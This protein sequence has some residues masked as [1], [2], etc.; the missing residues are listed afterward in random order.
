[1]DFF[2]VDVD[3]IKCSVPYAEIQDCENIIN[4][5]ANIILES[6]GIVNPLFVKKLGFNSYELVYGEVEYYAA[7]KAS[8]I[9]PRKGEM[10]GAFVI[11]EEQEEPI[12]IQVDFLR[13]CL[14]NKQNA[15]D[16]Q[17]LNN[18]VFLTVSSNNNKL[19]SVQKDINQ[20]YEKIESFVE[21]NTA[22]GLKNLL[23]KQIES[24]IT[25]AE[26]KS[27]KEAIEYLKQSKAKLLEQQ[28]KIDDQIL[29]LSKISLADIQSYE[30]LKILMEKV[31]TKSTQINASWKAIQ[32]WRNSEEGLTW[33]NLKKSTG[34][35]QSDH[36]ID[37]F[38]QKTYQKLKKVAYL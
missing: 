21:M 6:G 37:K 3:T 36:K 32:H 22:K 8:E 4:R 23:R 20:L 31:N 26:T 25:E 10:I 17:S 18:E 12:K 34:G 19:N 9:D 14:S 2:L 33:E 13:K 11:E 30:Q 29:E 35:E 38:G 7:V 24:I 27:K 16:D 15:E 5:L 28:N 1:M